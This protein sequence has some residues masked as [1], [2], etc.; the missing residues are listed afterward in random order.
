MCQWQ[1]Q[2][3]EGGNMKGKKEGKKKKEEAGEAASSSTNN[4]G[5]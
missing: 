3:I 4:I 1:W 5:L 2:S